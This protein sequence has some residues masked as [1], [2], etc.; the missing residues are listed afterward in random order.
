MSAF[1]QIIQ[2]KNCRH[3]IKNC[4]TLAVTI[5][6]HFIDMLSQWGF[7]DIQNFSRYSPL[8]KDTFKI[9]LEEHLQITGVI[10]S[11]ELFITIAKTCPNL[12]AGVEASI[13]SWCL[14]H[15]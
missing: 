13:Q 14:E 3:Y 15:K 4:Y 9:D 12:L 6:S 10:N 1:I 8:A 7:L 11:H 2:V 5:D